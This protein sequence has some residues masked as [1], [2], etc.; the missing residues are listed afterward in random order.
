[1]YSRE[2]GSCITDACQSSGTTT[3]IVSIVAILTDFDQEWVGCAMQPDVQ[4]FQGPGASC[5]SKEISARMSKSSD[6]HGLE[7]YAPGI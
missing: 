2:V 1:M 6:R 7:I 4:D 3:R 5:R